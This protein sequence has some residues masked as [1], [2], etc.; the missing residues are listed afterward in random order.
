MIRGA[1]ALGLAIKAYAIF[2]EYDVMVTSVLSLV[3]L[4]T[5]VFGSFMPMVANCLLDPPK[6][7]YGKHSP[8]ITAENLD[9]TKEQLLTP[10]S[11]EFFVPSG[12]SN[13]NFDQR[14]DASPLDGKAPQRQHVSQHLPMTKEMADKLIQSAE[15]PQYNK[16]AG[17]PNQE[18]IPEK[19]AH[20]E[21]SE[22]SEF[23][24]PNL[25]APSEITRLP[26]TPSGHPTQEK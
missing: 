9:D 5:L 8:K 10:Q 12:D 22:Y 18:T 25:A 21:G 11:P 23:I 16:L 19:S 14:R 7:K 1:I 2:T 15:S 24:A 4:S 26:L 6:T 13:S 20:E 3:I 17:S